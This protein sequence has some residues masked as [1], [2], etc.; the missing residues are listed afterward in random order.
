[1]ARIINI[2]SIAILGMCIGFIFGFRYALGM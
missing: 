1:M 2:T